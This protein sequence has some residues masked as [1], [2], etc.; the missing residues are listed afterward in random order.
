M[1]AG[2]IPLPHWNKVES[3]ESVQG[4]MS[5]DI[6]L[7]F[8]RSFMMRGITHISESKLHAD[9]GCFVHFRLE[10][11]WGKICDCVEEDWF[12]LYRQ[13]SLPRIVNTSDPRHFFNTSYRNFFAQLSEMP[14]LQALF[15]SEYP[16]FPQYLGSKLSCEVMRVDLYTVHSLWFFQ[17]AWVGWCH[18]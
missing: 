7:W 10:L 2:P 14:P 6:C 8:T 4:R 18:S 15:T 16:W 17:D 9:L 12:C 1:D 5:K 11:K 13:P 3:G